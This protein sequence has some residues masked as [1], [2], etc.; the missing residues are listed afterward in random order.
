LPR[1]PVCNTSHFGTLI[2]G[3]PIA[4]RL[5]A[6]AY[7]FAGLLAFALFA[8]VI[9]GTLAVLLALAPREGNP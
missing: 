6:H 2:F 7:S 8:A 9:G 3:S 4:T 1:F 5:H